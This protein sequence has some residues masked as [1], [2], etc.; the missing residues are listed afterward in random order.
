MLPSYS[1]G[2]VVY[3]RESAGLGFL[4]AVRISEVRS[5]S[6]EWIY[7]IQARASQPNSVSYG[8]RISHV[9]G[10]VLYFSES[11]L[12]SQ[13]EALTIMEAAVSANLIKI[14]QMKTN[15]CDNTNG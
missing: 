6:S 8:D 14:Q 7:S 4:E 3:L 15:L 13:C 10:Q 11:E 2:D 9:N 5:R 12:I 1:V